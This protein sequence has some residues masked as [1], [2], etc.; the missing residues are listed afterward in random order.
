MKVIT[1]K[2][3][4]AALI[5]Y[6][7]K[8]YEFRTW[9]TKYRGDILIQASKSAD[10]KAMEEFKVYDLDYKFGCIIA[11]AKISDVIKVDDNFRKV[12]KEKNSLV[13]KHIIDDREYEGY[14]F[15][16]EDVCLIEPIY[17]K[18][19]LGLWNYDVE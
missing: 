7:I 11:K 8:E 10:K 3:P 18:G 6:G 13:Y 12:L 17:V 16:I 19:K 1:I 14:A 4:Y 5:A 2:Q 15:K 9:N